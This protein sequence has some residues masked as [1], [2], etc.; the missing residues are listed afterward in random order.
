MLRY[1]SSVLQPL[2]A[3]SGV[4]GATNGAS[5]T[6]VAGSGPGIV[7]YRK[8]HAMDAIDEHSRR[9]VRALV[10]AGH[11]ASYVPDG[12]P[13]ARRVADTPPWI[14]LQ[15]MPFSYGRWG[16]APGIVRDAMAIKR[17]SGALLGVMVH[18]A[19][20]AMDTWR[21]SLMGAY[22]RM[23]LRSLLVLAD[24]VAASTESFARL[25]G[26]RAVHL[27]VGSNISPI[28]MSRDAARKELGIEDELVIALFGTSNPHRML[29]HSET[30]LTA[31]VAERG[32]DKIRVLNLGAG[33]R[34]L[35]VPQELDVLTPGGLPADDVSRHLRASDLLLLSFS[36]GVSTR[37]GTL[38]AGLAHGLPV[39]AVRGV[40]TDDVLLRH[41]DA[42]TLTPVGDQRAFAQAVLDITSDPERL[43]RA[44]RAGRALY[45]THFDWPVAAERLMTVFT[46]ARRISPRWA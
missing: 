43:M 25:F 37:R 28:A 22:Q 5:S 12:L 6:A 32:A 35:R 26:A 13:A 17:A 38:M 45:S 24:V 42:I 36:D 27:P 1:A 19:W 10:H 44:G 23:Q 18:E 3:S 34:A 9:L 40:S 14:L 46:N 30:A 2:C 8:T 7:V 11:P 16:F 15:Y 33:A 41:P 39:V 4:I 20:V 31:L 21:T 29:E